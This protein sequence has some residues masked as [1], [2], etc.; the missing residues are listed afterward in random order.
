MAHNEFDLRQI[1][2]E[3]RMLT[4]VVTKTIGR[5][6]QDRL[7]KSGHAITSLQLGLMRAILSGPQTISEVSKLMMFDPS[8]LVPV[9]DS[10]ETRG[11]VE[12]RKD[13]ADR[14]RVPIHLT[15]SGRQLLDSMMDM[16]DGDLLMEALAQLKPE[17]ALQLRDL[18]RELL[19]ALPEGKETLCGMQEHMLRIPPDANA[20][21]ASTES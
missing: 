6:M 5:A 9:V 8:T 18:L 10:L 15:D 14:R 3:V 13:P 2:A 20:T 17:D 1:T 19:N 12:R 16:H 21:T 4:V 7:A 11:L